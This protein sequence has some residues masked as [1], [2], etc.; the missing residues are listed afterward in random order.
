M[1][2]RTF[3]VLAAPRQEVFKGFRRLVFFELKAGPRDSD[4]EAA[5]A[6]GRQLRGRSGRSAA[7]RPDPAC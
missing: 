4:D 5:V 3:A 6:P 2:D 1:D 7:A